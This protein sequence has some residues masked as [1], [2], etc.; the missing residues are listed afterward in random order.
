MH[1]TQQILRSIH[2]HF[3]YL[4]SEWHTVSGT[5]TKGYTADIFLGFY[6]SYW[7]WGDGTIREAQT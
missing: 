5:E 7:S 1:F 2:A 3:V 6:A 4:L